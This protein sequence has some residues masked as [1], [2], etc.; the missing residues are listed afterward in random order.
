LPYHYIYNPVVLRKINSDES[1]LFRQL[2]SLV[3]L[4]K[5]QAWES[6]TLSLDTCETGVALLIRTERI[7][8]YGLQLKSNIHAWPRGPGDV[9]D[10]MTMQSH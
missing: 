1:V 3:V 10:A 9:G 6:V 2:D 5:N 4:A 7:T 8:N